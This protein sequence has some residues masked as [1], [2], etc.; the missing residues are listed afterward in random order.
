MGSYRD[1]HFSIR[2]ESST[3]PLLKIL[4][5]VLSELDPKVCKKI[6]NNECVEWDYWHNL[7]G[8]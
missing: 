2:E 3:E 7:N 6:E 5:V 1:Y 4:N 8:D